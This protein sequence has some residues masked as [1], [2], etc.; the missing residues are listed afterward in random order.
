MALS[1][2]GSLINLKGLV[3]VSI[4]SLVAV[5]AIHFT[6]Q[7][8][9]NNVNVNQV[10]VINQELGSV[11]RSFRLLWNLLMAIVFV[12]YPVAGQSYNS[13]LAAAAIFGIPLSIIAFVVT[14]RGFGLARIWDV[15]YV[16]GVTL[17]CW[18]IACSV[19]SLPVA[20]QYAGQIR[21][22]ILAIHQYGLMP[23]LDSTVRD[24]YILTFGAGLTT[25]LGFTFLFLAT[26][27]LLFGF[28]RHRSLD[29]AP[30]HTCLYGAVGIAGYMPQSWWAPGSA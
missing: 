1:D 27:Y 6:W 25:L 12:T 11:R 22:V 17:A 3:T 19:S 8:S 14:I 9:K 26:G 24:Q 30:R 21:E 18:L 29:E 4:G 20:A 5:K 28:S 7:V 10:T 15:F 23:I 13:V 16:L 2:L